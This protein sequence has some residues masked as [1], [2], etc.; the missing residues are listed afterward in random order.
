V[1]DRAALLAFKASGD[2]AAWPA[3]FGWTVESSFS[4]CDWLGV[5]CA[6]GRVT[7]LH[8]YFSPLSLFYSERRDITGNIAILAQLDQLTQLD[9][10]FTGVWGDVASLGKLKGLALLYVYDSS[11][12]GYASGVCSSCGDEWSSGCV[13]TT[14]HLS[15][16][17]LVS[18]VVCLSCVQNFAASTIA[19][20]LY[21]RV[22]M[23]SCS[24]AQVV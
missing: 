7:E 5:T 4:V 23:G 14:H 3:L 16:A 19:A 15:L 2:A 1:S 20:V 12:G 17:C 21:I 8:L 13:T 24:T 22:V 10:R 6:G 11:V 18:G 9:V